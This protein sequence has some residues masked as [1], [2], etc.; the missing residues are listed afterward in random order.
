MAGDAPQIGMIRAATLADLPQLVALITGLA[1]HHSDAATVTQATVA[2]DVFGPHPCL[3]ILVAEAADGLQAYAAL[4]QLARLQWG[5][6]GM[7]LHHLYVAEN[8]RGTGLGTRLIQAVTDLA[9]AQ[10]CSYLTVSA[11]ASN[12]R[13][14]DFYTKRGFRSAPVSGQRFALDLG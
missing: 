2:R 3:Q 13:A 8:A 5:Q 9:R 11:L 4:T 7:D 14:Q 6:R 10:G 1:A 12:P